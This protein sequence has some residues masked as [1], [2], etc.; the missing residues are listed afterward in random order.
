MGEGLRLADIVKMSEEELFLL[1]GSKNPEEGTKYLAEEGKSLV[2]V[3]S[4]P[5]RS[6]LPER[7]TLRAFTHL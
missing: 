3:F 1:T 4:G 2:L 7:R 6:L 5:K